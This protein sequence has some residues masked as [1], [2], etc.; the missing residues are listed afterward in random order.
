MF[1]MRLAADAL[2]G[3]DANMQ[4]ED[5]SAELAGIRMGNNVPS[6]CMAVETTD[7]GIACSNGGDIITV[8]NS[9]EPEV[10]NAL[11]EYFDRVAKH[12]TELAA[13]VSEDSVQTLVGVAASLLDNPVALVDEQSMT[14]SVACREDDALPDYWQY[15]RINGRLPWNA[16]EFM[17]KDMVF[18]SRLLKSHD[19][20][21]IVNI[22]GRFGR[23][24]VLSG[25]EAM[26][27]KAYGDGV[28]NPGFRS[29]SES[30]TIVCRMQGSDGFKVY[31]FVL[32]SRSRI[33]PGTLQLS[34]VVVASARE[35]MD[36]HQGVQRTFSNADILTRIAHGEEVSEEDQ[37]NQKRVMGLFG[38][39][40][41]LVRIVHPKNRGHAWAASVFQD[42][43]DKSHCFEVDGVLYSLCVSYASLVD[44][45]ESMASKFEM[46]FGLSWRFYDWSIVP[47]AVNQTE[48]AL[49]STAD[50]VAVLDSHSVLFY[51]FSI[52]MSST[53][54]IDIIH[55]AINLLANYDEDHNSEYL[56]TLWVYLRH[57]RNLVHTA[58]DLNIHRNSLVYRVKKISELIPAVDLDDPE[59]REHL[60]IS[61]R[62]KGLKDR[63][64]DEFDE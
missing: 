6:D 2:N 13:A 33:T 64:E 49:S 55:P 44:D 59:T 38:A 26:A 9:S 57:E 40:Y 42:N 46:R 24:D 18:A 56:R 28:S 14:C 8:K 41:V 29:V 23:L 58:E 61:F 10:L 45:L 31:L 12:E 60:M 63:T 53:K 21:F 43:I 32:G 37:I 47:E 4:V 35:W 3:F 52:L 50:R 1:T 39:E 22:G 54:D 11:L 27:R 19:E 15:A 34:K 48:V 7:T 62:L 17:D 16:L 30:E 36:R 5:G 51:I 25:S 20:P